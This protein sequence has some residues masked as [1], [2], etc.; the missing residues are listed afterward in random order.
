M[1]FKASETFWKNFYRLSSAQKE[2][3]R[4]AW[5]LFKQDPFD[6]R[7]RPHKIHQLSAALGKTVFAVEIEGDLRVVFYLDGDIVRTVDVGTHDIYKP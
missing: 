4:K 1:R 2:S 3:A 5:S 6:V 7:L